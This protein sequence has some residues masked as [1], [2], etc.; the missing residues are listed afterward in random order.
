MSIILKK[1]RENDNNTSNCGRKESFLHS[2]MWAMFDSTTLD[3]WVIDPSSMP[4]S[5]GNI[6]LPTLVIN[7]GKLSPHI[8]CP[9]LHKCGLLLFSH[10]QVQGDVKLSV[11]GD[12]HFCSD[13]GITSQQLIATGTGK[14]SAILG[15]NSNKLAAKQMSLNGKGET[16]IK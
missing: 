4:V 3:V 6:Y 12:T 15:M 11:K 14:S 10:L 9:H 5:V 1:R 8:H 7:V 16:I 13:S 2:Y